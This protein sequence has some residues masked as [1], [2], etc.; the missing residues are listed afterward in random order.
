MKSDLS[1]LLAMAVSAFAPLGTQAT[2]VAGRVRAT[3]RANRIALTTI[4]YAELLDGRA[5]IRPGH[6][7]MAQKNKAFNPHVLAVPVGSTVEFP[8]Q[9]PIFHNIF[10]MSRPGPFDL[11]LYEAGTSKSRIFSEPTTY[12]VFCNIH[13]QMT[14]VILVLPTSFITETTSSGSYRLDLPPGHYRITAWSERAQPALV[15]ATVSSSAVTVPDLPLDE[16][17]FVE[18]PHKNKYG[19]DYPKSSDGKDYQP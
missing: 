14:A 16:S 17:K 7:K 2:E 4:V 15:E 5:P 9:D 11:G 13:P 8:N 18:L 10:S 6:Y 19:Q 12:R 1:I 3:G